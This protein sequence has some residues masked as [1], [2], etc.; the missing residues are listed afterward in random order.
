MIK[1]VKEGLTRGEVEEDTTWEPESAFGRIRD[2]LA[3]EYSK[4]AEDET[5]RIIAEFREIIET[6]D[7]K[8]IVDKGI[9]LGM[10]H[11]LTE[12]MISMVQLSEFLVVEIERYKSVEARGKK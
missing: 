2:E 11:S 1:T 10:L 8:D 12:T 6:L 4:L 3:M 9:L 7:N 5:G